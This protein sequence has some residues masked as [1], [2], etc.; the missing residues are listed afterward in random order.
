LALLIAHYEIGI[1]FGHFL[2][3]QTKLRRAFLVA[4]VVKRHWLEHQ[5]GFTGFVH[6]LNL[7]FEP[8]GGAGSPKLAVDGHDDWHRGGAYSGCA[9]NIADPSAVAHGHSSAARPDSNNV[10]GRSDVE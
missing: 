7:L 1:H 9:I 10:I 8:P 2:G 6:R 4:L 3:D 5:D